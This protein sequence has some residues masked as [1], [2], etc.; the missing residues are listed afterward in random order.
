MSCAGG[1]CTQFDPHAM[2]L[3][4]FDPGFTS[5]IQG[6]DRLKVRMAGELKWIQADTIS[7]MEITR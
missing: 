5:F 2:I 1:R 4:R 6:Q 3:S 7:W